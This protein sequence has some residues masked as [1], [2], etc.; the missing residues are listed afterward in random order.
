MWFPQC[1]FKLLT[2]WSCPSCGIQRAIHAILNNRWNEA[3]AYN[4]FFIISIPYLLIIGIA[5]I[6]RKL[7]KLYRISE[8]FEHKS[9]AT[10]Y[11]H[12]FFAWF[13]IRNIIGI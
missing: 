4:Y 2:G 9:L 12:C 8:L 10:I 3:L 7:Q 5:Y 6:L 13:I 11:V 1:P